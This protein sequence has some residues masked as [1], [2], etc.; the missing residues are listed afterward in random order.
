VR[1]VTN[2]IIWTSHVRDMTHTRN[3][4]RLSRVMSLT[5]TSHVSDISHESCLWHDERHD[6]FLVWMRAC[7]C[8]CVWRMCVCVCVFVCV[9]VWVWVGERRI[10]LWP[11]NRWETY[12]SLAYEGSW[13]RNN[14][15]RDILTRESRLSFFVWMSPCLCE[16]DVAHF[17]YEHARIHRKEKRGRMSWSHE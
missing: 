4:R 6:S 9:C 11:M 1:D 8:V 2:P 5:L 13:R 16:R 7:L 12:K 17:L 10:S 14:R 3:E 15:V